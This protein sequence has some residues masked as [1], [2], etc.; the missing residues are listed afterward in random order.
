GVTFVFRSALVGR[1]LGRFVAHDPT[2]RLWTR[3]SAGNRSRIEPPDDPPGVTEEGP[4]ADD[5][6]LIWRAKRLRPSP[7]A[8]YESG[9]RCRRRIA[10]DRSP[11]ISAVLEVLARPR[12]T[13]AILEGRGPGCRSRVAV[14]R[15]G[16]PRADS[17]PNR[18]DWV[19]TRFL[20]CRRIANRR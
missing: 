11:A 14:C 9:R 18:P 8:V 3:D 1:H 5:A 4:I 7:R 6:G 15:C 2:L 13:S 16:R 10:S 19:R 17:F 20:T 12:N